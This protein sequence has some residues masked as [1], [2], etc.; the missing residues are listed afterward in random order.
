[1]TTI[2]VP[3]SVRD[4]VNEIANSQGISAGSVIEA[5]LQE[6]IERSIMDNVRRK[7]QS[8]TAEEKAEYENEIALWDCTSGDGLEEY[9]GEWDGEW[10][11]EWEAELE[12]SPELRDK[13]GKK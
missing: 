2:R 8:M 13:Y 12:R 6:H 5:L 1:M 9:A 4:Q 10:D 7:M 3:Q 11:G